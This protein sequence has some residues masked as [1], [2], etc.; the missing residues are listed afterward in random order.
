ML[1]DNEKPQAG[2]AWGRGGFNQNRIG[3]IVSR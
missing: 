3:Y 1:G 2:T